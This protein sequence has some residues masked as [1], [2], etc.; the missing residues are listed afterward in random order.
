MGPTPTE[1]ADR[2]LAHV[3]KMA[4]ELRKG[5]YTRNITKCIRFLARALQYLQ[6]QRCKR[7]RMNVDTLGFVGRQ[8]ESEGCGASTHG[9]HSAPAWD[10]QSN[11]ALHGSV[12]GMEVRCVAN[13]FGHCAWIVFLMYFWSSDGQLCADKC[14]LVSMVHDRTLS[15]SNSAQKLRPSKYE[16]RARSSFGISIS[17]AQSFTG[18]ESPLKTPPKSPTKPVA[19]AHPPPEMAEGGASKIATSNE[20]W[21]ERAMNR[22]TNSNGLPKIKAQDDAE[23]GDLF[24]GAVIVGICSCFSA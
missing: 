5:V 1:I 14:W 15:T 10:P 2:L 22:L 8:T 9:C 21:L 18:S 6:R 16:F 12:F 17:R 19:E 11:M 7:S 20:S 24:E 13:V 4:S 3:D 23:T